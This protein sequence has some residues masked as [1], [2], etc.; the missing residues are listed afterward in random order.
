MQDRQQSNP[1]QND[2]YP[3]LQPVSVTA[4][5]LGTQ[6]NP[7]FI[8]S[9]SV[10]FLIGATAN[11]WNGLLARMGC[12]GACQTLLAVATAIATR[13][14]SVEAEAA[15]GIPLGFASAAQF[16]QACADLCDALSE[17]GMSDF[18]VGVRGS[19]IT[20]ASFSTGVPAL[21]RGQRY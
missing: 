2:P 1:A 11:A 9:N 3:Q 17:S 10:G 7:D 13:G 15:E 21:R 8:D 6:V 5:A 20:G 18:T 19:S 12:K 16:Q 14:A 4:T